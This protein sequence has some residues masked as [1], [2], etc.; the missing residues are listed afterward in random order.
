[1]R[2]I[3]ITAP[4]GPQTPVYPGDPA[5]VVAPLSTADGLDRF[6]LSRLTLGT[7]AGTHVDPPSHLFPG[8]ATVDNLPLD[9]LIGPARLVDLVRGRSVTAGD[10][11]AVPHRTVRLL[12]RTGGAPLCEGAARALVARGVRLVGVDGLSVDAIDRPGPAHRVLLGAGVVVV[13]GL[14]LAGVAPGSYTLI[15]LPLR[16]VAGDGAPARAVLI[17]GGEEHGLPMA[18]DS[19]R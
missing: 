1:M 10:L 15:C 11:E 14:A 7:H 8:G 18:A 5:I 9:V 3:D 12:L 13:E 17:E 19:R 2:I 4:L 16:L 6:A